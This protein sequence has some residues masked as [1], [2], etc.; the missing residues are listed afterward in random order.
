MDTVATLLLLTVVLLAVAAIAHFALRGNKQFPEGTTRSGFRGWL[1][2]LAIVQRLVL[3]RAI[4]DFVV[5]LPDY[6][7]HWNNPVMRR[8]IYAEAGITLAILPLFAYATV[9][10]TLK[11][12]IFRSCSGSRWFCS[13]CFPG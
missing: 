9:I 3:L 5:A 2:V 10:M 1:L 8:A 7:E 11:R 6:R 4:A 13:S 12:R